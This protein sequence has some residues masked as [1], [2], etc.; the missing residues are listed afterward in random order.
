MPALQDLLAEGRQ[1]RVRLDV[2]ADDRLA[3]TQGP[4]RRSLVDLDAG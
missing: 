1:R 3:V 4:E 2:V